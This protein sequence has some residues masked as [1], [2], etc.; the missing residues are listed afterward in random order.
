MIKI[1]AP[2]RDKKIW[3]IMSFGIC[4]RHQLAPGVGSLQIGGKMVV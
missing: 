2:D 3:L 1:A 4:T